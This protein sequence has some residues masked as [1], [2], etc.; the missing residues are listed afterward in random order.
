MGQ[1]SAGHIVL[2]LISIASWIG[3]AWVVVVAARK[4]GLFNRKR[5]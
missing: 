2:I 3:A 4:M 5:K 1:V